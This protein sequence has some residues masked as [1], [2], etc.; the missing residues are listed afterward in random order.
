MTHRLNILLAGAALAALVSGA[1]AGEVTELKPPSLP[2]GTATF[3]NGKV[4]NLSVGFGSGAFHRPGDAEGTIFTITDRGPNI[5]CAA[6]VK[7]MIGLDKDAICGGNEAAKVFPLP[8]FVPTIYELTIGADGA[9]A[10]A[11]TIPLKGTGGN[12]L[13]GLSNPLMTTTTEGAFGAD[14]KEITKSPD[15][16]DTEGLVALSDGTFWVADEYG[17]SIAHVGADGTVIKRLVPAGLEGDYKGASYPVEGKLPALV[18]KR[19]LNRGIESI[20]VS[21]DEKSLY[22][23]MQSPLANPDKDAYKASRTVRLFKFDIA[24]EAVTGEYAYLL[25]EPASFKKDEA[26]KAG[27]QNDVKVSELAAVGPDQLLVLERI[28]RTTKL[29]RVDLAKASTVPAAFDDPAA[30]PTLEQTTDLAAAGVVPV[31]K[32]LVLDSDDLA[33]MPGKIESI[34]VV[35]GQD[36][37]LVSDNDFGIA[38]DESRVVRVHLDA[39]LTN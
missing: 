15:G 22:F 12:A 1:V 31:E 34:A 3:P 14:G 30:S 23:S 39:P 20:A 37:V 7:D 4:L 13:N 11:R 25:D 8:A 9:I 16:F 18:M 6:D 26:K 36:I 32:S 17:A 33:D 24:S 28:A 10:V 2:L 5:D 27:K 29:Y 38:G 19:Y 35:G 21:P